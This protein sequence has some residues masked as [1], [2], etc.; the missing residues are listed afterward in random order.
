MLL[1]SDNSPHMYSV[2][3]FWPMALV[4]KQVSDRDHPEYHEEMYMLL[5]LWNSLSSK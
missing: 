3:L 2:S 4:E 1:C 5:S